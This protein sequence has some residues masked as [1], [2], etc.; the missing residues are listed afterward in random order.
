MG[1]GGPQSQ[2]GSCEEVKI[3]DRTGNQATTPLVIQP[4]TSRY[5]GYSI[6]ALN[7]VSIVYSIYGYGMAWQI[8]DLRF[9][10]SEINGPVIESVSTLIN[11]T[12][13]YK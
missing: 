12:L 8:S 5:T 4:T 11:N 1:L 6:L 13:P 7:N 3:L 10:T 2:S 9:T